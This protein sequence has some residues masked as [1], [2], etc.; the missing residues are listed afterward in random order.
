MFTFL[1][2][3]SQQYPCVCLVQGL[4]QL[5]QGFSDICGITTPQSIQLTV[6][7]SKPASF[8]ESKW[9]ETLIVMCYMPLA[10][11]DSESI[12]NCLSSG[13]HLCMLGSDSTTDSMYLTI[14]IFWPTWSS[15]ETLGNGKG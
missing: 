9:H 6:N 2:V 1:P 12:T 5:I 11:S 3:D 15:R 4:R 14:S 8:R 7:P 10:V 13:V